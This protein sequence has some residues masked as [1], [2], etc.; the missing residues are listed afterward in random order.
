MCKW[1]RCAWGFAALVA[2]GEAPEPWMLTKRCIVNRKTLGMSKAQ[3]SIAVPAFCWTVDFLEIIHPDTREQESSRGQ[4]RW[5][6]G[7][8]LRLAQLP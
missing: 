4:A 2:R 8:H 6:L 7:D 3:E 5:G 1:R